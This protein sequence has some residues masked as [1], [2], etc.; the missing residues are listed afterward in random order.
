MWIFGGAGVDGAN[1][2]GAL[3]G[4]ISADPLEVIGACG[5]TGTGS[6]TGARGG[7]SCANYP[8]TGSVNAAKCS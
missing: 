8:T 2:G 5:A 7:I 3:N 6:G 4:R 1:Y